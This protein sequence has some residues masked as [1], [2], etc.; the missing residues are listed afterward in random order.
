M[1]CPECGI[2]LES[3][4]VFCTACGAEII[5]EPIETVETV[6]KKS[7]NKEKSKKKNGF[8]SKKKDGGEAAAD[9]KKKLKLAGVLALAVIVVVAIIIVVVNIVAMVKANEG[10]KILEKVPLGRDIEII[11]ADTKMDFVDTSV[12]GAVGHVAEFDYICESEKSIVVGGITVPEWAVVLEKS[13]DD[14]VNT[15]TLLN[16][17]AI[18]HNWMGEKTALTIDLS[19]IEF[20]TSIKRTERNLGLKPYTI[21]KNSEDNTSVYVYRYHYI[22][23]ETENTIVKNIYITVDDAEDKVVDAKDSQV[24]YMKLI[25][26]AE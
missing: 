1:K 3:N 21:I 4:A 19:V 5:N 15:A 25:L 2:E 6:E 22:D 18:E 23:D 17:N 20:G 12:Y 26:G 10:R 11:E 13:Y 8:F 9:K 16:F 24:D 14:S 7:E